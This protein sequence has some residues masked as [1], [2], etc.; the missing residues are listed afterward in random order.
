MPRVSA[1]KDID[2][3]IKKTSRKSS[4]KAKAVITPAGADIFNDKP[5]KKISLSDLKPLTIKNK[6]RKRKV[7][8]PETS[9]VLPE[10]N[11]SRLIEKV[12]LYRKLLS[13]RTPKIMRVVANVGGY[14]FIVS[15]IYLCFLVADIKEGKINGLMALTT[16]GTT[17][18]IQI[19]DPSTQITTTNTISTTTTQSPNT[20]IDPIKLL[21]PKVFFSSDFPKE[22]EVDFSIKIETKDIAEVRV[23]VTSDTTSD[24]VELTAKDKNVFLVSVG[25]LKPGT[26]TFRA[27]AIALDNITKYYFSGEK[28]II[29]SLE[30]TVSPSVA[31]VTVDSDKTDYTNIVTPSTTTTIDQQIKPEIVEEEDDL[32][33]LLEVHKL[34]GENNFRFIIKNIPD[35]RFVEV[36]A[37][38][39]LSN[40]PRFLGLAMKRD[41][42]WVFNFNGNELPIG[43]YEVF[44]KAPTTDGVFKSGSAFFSIT[45]YLLS[46]KTETITTTNEI[47]DPVILSEKV[48]RI[49]E[50]QTESDVTEPAISLLEK[51][52]VYFEKNDNDSSPTTE[53]DS[54]STIAKVEDPA[55]REVMELLEKDKDKLNRLLK[56]YA[57]TLQGEDKNLHRLAK[58]EITKYRDSLV[59]DSAINTKTKDISA[60]IAIELDKEIERLQKKVEKY[61][62][63]IKERSE[64][65]GKDSDNDG[66]T[67]FDELNL[68][69]TDATNPDSDSDG[70]LDGVEI[71]GGYNPNDADLEA[72]ISFHSPKDVNYVDE[73]HMKVESVTPII[74]TDKNQ[75]GVPVLAE[76][77]GK[78][79]PNSF[80]TLFI[81]SS[82]TVVSVKTDENGD[83]IYTFTKELEDGEHEVYIAITDNKGEIVARSNPFQFVKTA[84]AFTPVD[85]K[86]A[87]TVNYTEYYEDTELSSYNIVAAMGVVSFGL[88]LLMLG[89][90]L[91]SRSKE[92]IAEDENKQDATSV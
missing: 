86:D 37:R 38:P 44:I 25:T 70:V 62:A 72:V 79:L 20:I 23:F 35:S 19:T 54:T 40:N 71:V 48:K 53:F 80:V 12:N 46:E 41:N 56:R 33:P 63:L 50:E 58:D 75:G 60:Q 3:A 2:T 89:H 42:L 18:C 87:Q 13:A 26:Y 6:T 68:Y 4:V 27:K 43:N 28:F 92:V 78:G 73:E 1:K 59:T 16:C 90:T 85:A 17:D 65:V 45:K 24:S 76:I 67:D 74:E 31:D 9:V 22:P 32:K 82:P 51:R 39:K 69:K 34:D 77:K 57:S 11:N 84:E 88:I 66:I 83:F 15:G 61:E 91:R 29:K 10:K 49:F 47:A 14:T 8:E 21:E 5:K 55:K 7:V 52:S 36:Y 64:L 30:P 81:Y